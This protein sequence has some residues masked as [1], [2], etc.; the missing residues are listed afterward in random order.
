MIFSGEQ[1]LGRAVN[2]YLIHYHRER[3]HQGLGNKLIDPTEEVGQNAGEIE[4]RER[5]GGW[6]KHY[7]RKAS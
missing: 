5:L 2:I 3:N 7:N 6:L 1:S 4:C